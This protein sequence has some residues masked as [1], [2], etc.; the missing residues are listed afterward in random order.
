MLGSMENGFCM[1][2]INN[3]SLCNK[4]QE[5]KINK[6]EN[7]KETWNK[8]MAALVD[9]ASKLN[10]VDSDDDFNQIKKEGVVLKSAM[11]TFNF[12]LSDAFNQAEK[13]FW[14]T[15]IARE[16]TK[17]F[18]FWNMAALV[19]KASKLNIVDSDDDFN[20]IKKEGV[21]LK[22]AMSTFNFPLSDAFN[23]A[24]KNF[25]ATFIARENTKKF[26]FWNMAALV[27][28]ASKL[29]IVDSD[30][31]F[32]QIKKEGVVLKSAMSTF[33]FPL[34]DTF[35]QAEKNFWATFIARENTKKFWFWNMAALV[36]KASKLNIVD[37]DD[38]FNQIKK[39]GVVLKSAMSTFNFPLSD[40]FNQ[41]EKS[42][43]NKLIARENTKKLWKT[44]DGKQ[45]YIK[46]GNAGNCY[47][48]VLLYAIATEFSEKQK[49]GM[50]YSDENENIII[51]VKKDLPY[52][53]DINT[54]ISRHG[55]GDYITQNSYSK[56]I[57]IKKDGLRNFK[58][59]ATSNLELTKIFESLIGYYHTASI[60]AKEGESINANDPLNK[61]IT[62][63]NSGW[64]DL[65]NGI[66]PYYDCIRPQK[67]FAIL[68]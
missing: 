34:S 6:Y 15:F 33:D 63:S 35:N 39:E 67:R 2:K 3:G 1:K 29:N 49:F 9:K 40:A 46:Q 60:Y 31:D 55:G 44:T 62:V 41:A 32:N 22:S 57:T 8:Q 37:S 61:S 11:S 50:I 26:W 12:P 51:N 7:I 42:F 25:W 5:N 38:D 27:D 65:L 47:L 36:D 24:E 17:K 54:F 18:W 30:D 53:A 56:T 14:A 21:V 23:Q 58:G 45:F 59:N 68:K 16:N 13:N 43:C 10:I 52:Q 4:A 19:D 28:K 20:Q 64:P 48:L 66:F